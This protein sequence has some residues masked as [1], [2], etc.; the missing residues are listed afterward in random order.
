MVI[1][2][3]FPVFFLLTLGFFLKQVRLTGDAFLKASDK[4]VYYIFFPA[5]LFWKIGGSKA[6][7]GMD[8]TYCL[9]AVGAVISMM[10]IS[11]LCIMLFRVHS[12]QAGS[13]SQSCYRFNTYIGMAVIINALGMEGI[14]YFGI[15]ISI[16][17]PIIN[18]Y[19][20]SS[21][22]WLS[23]GRQSFG[24]RLRM[25]IKSMVSNP[26]II[27][28]VVGL[29]YSHYVGAFPDFLEN[30]FRLVTSVA[31][32]LALLSIGG[33]L[34]LRGMTSH[35]KL[36]ALSA[37]LKMVI[38]P[39][40]GYAGMRYFGVTGLPFKVSM[41]FFALPTAASVYVLS[42]QLNSDTDLASASIVVSTL[43]SF[44]SLTIAI[45]L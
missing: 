19:A 28:C 36:S 22:I 18:M 15:L 33:S 23:G 25:M 39:L 37:V 9:V 31:L 5:L 11:L 45:L 3:L 26:L 40:L 2:S 17:I 21:L 4:L 27:G 30:T 34:T 20:V 43:F 1:N 32:P 6:S 16:L 41:I 24:Q 38:L 42:S 14:R 35:I 8:L 10:V 13:F 7:D 44:L 29:V 12:F